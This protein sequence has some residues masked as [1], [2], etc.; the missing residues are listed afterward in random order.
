MLLSELST[1]A[2]WLPKKD[3][4]GKNLWWKGLRFLW[5][6]RKQTPVTEQK[7]CIYSFYKNNAIG[8]LKLL[9]SGTKI[10]RVPKTDFAEMPTFAGKNL[11][12]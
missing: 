6:Y 9:V 5:F 2:T 4:T 8:V 10:G 3:D 12:P 11:L 1:I 7:S